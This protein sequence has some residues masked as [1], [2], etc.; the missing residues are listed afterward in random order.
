MSEDLFWKKVVNENLKRSHKI[1]EEE[2]K[3]FYSELQDLCEPFGS[4]LHTEHV[5]L[6]K[7]TSGRT[8]DLVI[9]GALIRFTAN[10]S[11]RLSDNLKKEYDWQMTPEQ[12]KEL[13]LDLFS[14]LYDQELVLEK[15][16]LD[17]QVAEFLEM[18]KKLLNIIYLLES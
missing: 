8:A 15:E 1:L 5:Q 11:L 2:V 9:L 16:F 4:K 6:D 14:Q 13:T 7:R 10:W 18:L 17:A 3:V 12:A